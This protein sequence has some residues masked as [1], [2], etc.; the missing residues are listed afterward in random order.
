MWQP[1]QELAYTFFGS[2]LN[3][4]RLSAGF[5]ILKS[6]ECTSAPSADDAVFTMW[7]EEHLERP[8]TYG[9]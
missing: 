5:M 3:M 9:E 6:C 2:F 4:T 7:Q 1:L 8:C